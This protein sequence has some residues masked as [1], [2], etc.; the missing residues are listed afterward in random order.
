MSK[1]QLPSFNC[2]AVGGALMIKEEDLSLVNEFIK[3]I[4]ILGTV[5]ANQGLFDTWYKNCLYCGHQSLVSPL[6]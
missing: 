5:L 4:A 2:K 6:F 1:F 3:D